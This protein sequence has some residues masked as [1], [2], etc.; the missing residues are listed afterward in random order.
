MYLASYRIKILLFLLFASLAALI[1]GPL[2]SNQ[3][4]P[5]NIDFLNHFA[6]II[7]AKIALTAGQFPLRIA[8]QGYGAW[9]YPVFQFYSPTS[10]MFSGFI[11]Q[12]LPQANPFIAYKMTIACALTLGGIYM[13]RCAYWLVKSSPAA[14]LASIAYLLSPYYL[15]VIYHLGAFNEAIALG[16][17][18]V[19]WYYAL[20]QY[21]SRFDYK[22]LL[23]SSFAWYLLATIHLITFIATTFFIFL[24]FIVITCKQPPYWK[25]LIKVGVGFL[26][27][28]LLAIWFLGPVTL[29]GKYLIITHTFSYIFKFFPHI[30]DLLAPYANFSLGFVAQ[31]GMGHS[32]SQI[33]PTIGLPILIAVGLSLTLFFNKKSFN[34]NRD[35]DL[36]TPLLI[37][38]MIAFLLVWSPV[39]FWQWLPKSF[40]VFQYTWR[41]LGQIMWIG[42]MLL[43][44]TLNWVFNKKIDKIYC[45]LLGALILVSSGS[46]LLF[47]INKFYAVSD[48]SL[49]KL[50]TILN[51]LLP[52]DSYLLNAKKFP[53]FIDIADRFF[54]NALSSSQNSFELTLKPI[55][56]SPTLIHS[57]AAPFVLL[58]G[59]LP[60]PIEISV[61]LNGINIAKRE[62]QEKFSWKIPLPVDKK[63]H[64]MVIQFQTTHIKSPGK[65]ILKSIPPEFKVVVGGLINPEKIL[66]LNQVKDHCQQQNDTTVCQI[67]VPTTIHL[68]ELPIYYYPG[69][70]SITLNDKLIPY[71]SVFY[72]D[73]VI[74]GIVAAPGELNTIKI[75]FRGFLWANFL[76]SAAW[77]LW[78][79]FLLFILF[80]R[81]FYR[82]A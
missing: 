28:C 71:F 78:L 3:D 15:I 1:L 33:H 72:D 39:N 31:N 12:W 16:M 54:L 11:Y 74:A 44:L 32:I 14:I 17:L 6:G 60:K 68:I 79:L 27:G 57:G 53:Q 38:F 29:L 7:Q 67:K 48:V 24:F 61:F 21:Y 10:Y 47:P 69:L 37:L 65:T 41:F 64:S 4:I 76:S 5:A 52:L 58:N 23:L 51:E 63:E 59:Y 46:W 40:W 82:K 73:K 55:V 43:A 56:I 20:Q 42:A 13:Y 77:Q 75:Q 19:V 62:L 9:P 18:P 30:T 50:P 25:N 34:L 49:N 81:F 80:R 26:Y 8:L 36:L 22:T 35:Y 70:L 45:V 66:D 2:A